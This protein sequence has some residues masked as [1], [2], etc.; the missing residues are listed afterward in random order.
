LLPFSNKYTEK[1]HGVEQC[2][3]DNLGNMLASMDKNYNVIQITSYRCI[4][5]CSDDFK[6]SKYQKAPE[7]SRTLIYFLDPAAKRLN[8]PHFVWKRTKI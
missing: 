8:F 7:L 5:R 4:A 2:E 3:N 1:K 6:K